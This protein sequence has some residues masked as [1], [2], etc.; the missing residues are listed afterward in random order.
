MSPIVLPSYRCERLLIRSNG[1][2][3]TVDLEKREISR[4]Y[5]YDLQNDYEDDRKISDGILTVYR[6]SYQYNLDSGTRIVKI[7]FLSG[8]F[9]CVANPNIGLLLVFV[10]G[11]ILNF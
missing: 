4:S 6:A 2:Y 11:A 1:D 5:F 8:T 10:V 9:N 3:Y 7:E